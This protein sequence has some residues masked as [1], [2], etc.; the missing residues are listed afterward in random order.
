MVNTYHAAD[1][2]PAEL[3]DQSFIE[4]PGLESEVSLAIVGHLD[5]GLDNVRD[6]LGGLHDWRGGDEDLDKAEGRSGHFPAG[7]LEQDK[8]IVQDLQCDWL[9]QS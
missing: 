3:P 5:Q 2:V 7:A 6:I 1:K 4:E 9:I 8:D